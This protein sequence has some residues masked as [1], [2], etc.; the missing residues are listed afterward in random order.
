VLTSDRPPRDLQALEDRLRER[1][2][3]GLVADIRPPDVDTRLAIL[4]KRV[5][6]DGI[7]LADPATLNVIAQRVALNV[8]ALEGALIRIVALSSLT[9]RPPSAE[10]ATEVLDNLYPHKAVR[11]RSLTEIQEA[12]CRH[13]DLSPEELLSPSRAARVIWPRQVAMYLARELTGES[14]PAIGRH[15]GGRDHTTVL[16]AWRRTAAKIH[17]DSTSRQAVDRLREQLETTPC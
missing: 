5:Q 11:P 13:F 1:F 9:G 10:L 17:T 6:Q 3:A 4:R 8:R 12:A 15:F 14:L 16:H 2:D 7:E